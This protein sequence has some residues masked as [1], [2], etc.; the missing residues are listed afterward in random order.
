MVF[1]RDSGI[2]RVELIHCDYVLA[3]KKRFGA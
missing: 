3:Y 2:G 1:Q